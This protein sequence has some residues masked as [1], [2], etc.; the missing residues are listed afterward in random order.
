MAA[1]ATRFPL[2]AEIILEISQ[3]LV[4]TGPQW[5]G[6]HAMP[7]L[8]H[9]NAFMRVCRQTHQILA[10]ELMLAAMNTAPT[11]TYQQ[12]QY[13]SIEYRL[14]MRNHYV[15]MA[16][17]DGAPVLARMLDYYDRCAQHPA[18]DFDYV[19]KNV[20]YGKRDPA[21]YLLLLPRIPWAPSL[22]EDL[23][24]R[25]L[26]HSVATLRIL[27]A[28]GADVNER[29]RKRGI[30]AL[31][32]ASRNWDIVPAILELGFVGPNDISGTAA[33]AVDHV[34][35]GYLKLEIATVAIASLLAAGAD[36]NAYGALH[37]AASYG[38]L[39]LIEALVNADTDLTKEYKWPL[40]DYVGYWLCHQD[41]GYFSRTVNNL[42]RI[43]KF[44]QTY[45]PR[46]YYDLACEYWKSTT[47]FVEG[48]PGWMMMADQNLDPPN[49]KRIKEL[50]TPPE[51][52]EQEYM[53]VEEL[54]ERTP[55]R[56][57]WMKVL[58]WKLNICG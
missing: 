6:P 57:W 25:G 47:K 12:P 2:P 23:E 53:H 33:K 51:W 55:V 8:A 52:I 28:R 16:A 37:L 42:K 30:S 18:L 22:V 41:T 7:S 43:T 34:V 54:P 1:C 56:R 13:K 49:M 38:N 3:H 14:S 20:L 9:L 24:D 48:D 15:A 50:L 44:K 31:F 21:A 58:N 35:R 29:H 19:G 26:Q 32:A 17:F 39:E 46:E 10:T 40:E 45:T 36:V 4:D 11:E 27:V 5:S